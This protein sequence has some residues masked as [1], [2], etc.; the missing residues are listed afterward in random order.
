MEHMNYTTNKFVNQNKPISKFYKHLTAIDRKNIERLL[1]LKDDKHYSG[2]KIT[3]QYIANVIGFDKSTVSREIKRGMLQTGYNASGP[4]KHYAWDVGERIAKKRSNRTKQKTKLNSN[5]IEIRRL[6]KIINK[7]KISP[8][9]AI[10]QYEL[11][12]NEKFPI[13]LKTVYK[14]IRKRIIKLRK[15]ILRYYKEIRVIKAP[16]E[17]KRI[18]KGDN[19]SKRPNEAE[20]RLEIGH[21]E[22]DTIYG[23]RDGSKECLLTLVDRRGRLFLVFKLP[24]RTAK[25]VVKTF[26][27]IEIK[28]GT[29]NFVKLFIS[30]TFDNGVEFTKIEEMEASCLK[31]AAQRIKTYFANAYHSWERATNENTNGWVRYYFP[32]GTNFSS[33]SNEK[34]RIVMNKI[35]YSVRRVLGGMS[36]MEFCEKERPELIEI[37]NKLGIE[38]PYQNIGSYLDAIV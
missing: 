33:V 9:D 31:E 16:K 25:S 34:L 21:W 6:A 27:E 7:E 22:G 4:I 8:E 36:S 17:A 29:Y 32:K 30:V 37:L 13:C 24:D 20:N 11:Y 12:Y 35:N 26:D 28:I 1:K 19:I 14:Y 23:S 15:G 18:Q 38:N 3:I 10:Y 5:N 2:P